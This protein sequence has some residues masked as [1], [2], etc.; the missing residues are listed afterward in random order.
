M[1]SVVTRLDLHLYASVPCL[2]SVYQGHFTSIS[3]SLSTLEISY[4]SS[5]RKAK[6]TVAGTLPVM[7]NSL[8]LETA[9]FTEAEFPLREN[10][11]TQTCLPAASSH[12][13]AL[14]CEDE[15]RS[16]LPWPPDSPLETSGSILPFS[17]LRRYLSFH[18]WH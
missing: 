6:T 15:K 11:G 2:N 17:N 1:S 13:W 8:F 3:S 16:S 12:E 5:P 18:L 7:E 14:A 10:S 4:N 9:S